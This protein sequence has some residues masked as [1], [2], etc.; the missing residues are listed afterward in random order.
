MTTARALTGLKGR[1]PP[2]QPGRDGS[3]RR[4]LRRAEPLILGFLGIAIVVLLW[5]S[6]IAA[7]LVSPLLLASPQATAEALVDYFASGEIWPHLAASGR[8]LFVGFGIAVVLGTTVGVLAGWFTGL[9]AVLSP[10]T[11]LPYATPSVALMP[12]FIVWFGL[13]FSSQLA[14]VVL[15]AFF[16]CY[17]AGADAVRTTDRSLTRVA[18]SFGGSDWRIFRSIVIPGSVPGILSGTRIAMGKAIVAVTV[19]ELYASSQGLGYLLIINGNRFKT[20]EVFA[21]LAIIAVFGLVSREVLRLI[22]RRF[23]TWRV[24]A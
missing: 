5:Q 18:R 23:D 22:E 3:V 7:E 17:F 20:A 11:A 8:L 13:G 10:H 6:I 15:L 2:Q 16:P 12:L 24:R 14:V 21:V 19:V 9:R 1:H 4:A